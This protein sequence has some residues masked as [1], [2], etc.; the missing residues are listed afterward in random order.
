MISAFIDAGYHLLSYQ[1]KTKRLLYIINHFII[2]FLKNGT[3]DIEKMPTRLQL[4]R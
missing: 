4:C 1:G 2:L 3:G